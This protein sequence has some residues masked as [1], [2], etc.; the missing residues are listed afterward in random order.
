M[1]TRNT[2]TGSKVEVAAEIMPW[3]RFK[4]PAPTGYRTE[5]YFTVISGGK[6]CEQ[7][8]GRGTKR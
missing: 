2:C 5:T 3:N 7:K 4:Q 8:L 1:H 6:N